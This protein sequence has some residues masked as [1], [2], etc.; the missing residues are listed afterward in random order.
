[1]NHFDIDTEYR[2]KE[3]AG[4]QLCFVYILID[5]GKDEIF[6]VGLRPDSVRHWAAVLETPWFPVIDAI[7]LDYVSFAAGIAGLVFSAHRL[8]EKQRVERRISSCI[9]EYQ[10]QRRRKSPKRRQWRMK[11]GGFEEVSRLAAA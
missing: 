2:F 8:P 1:M 3:L 7:P 5:Y 4:L 9:S 11:R 10:R 6:S